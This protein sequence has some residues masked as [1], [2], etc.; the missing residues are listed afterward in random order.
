M[1][2][3]KNER[4]EWELPGG[5]IEE[6]ETPEECLIRE[7]HE[8]LGLKCNVKKIIDS[9]VFEVVEGKFVFIVT[10]LCICNDTA[11][12]L[13]S[14]EH[15]EYRWFQLEEIEDVNMPEGYKQSIRKTNFKSKENNGPFES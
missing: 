8:E 6:N 15:K 11:S 13:I 12:I 3:L 2:L 10:Y 5:R 7:I 14:D 4:N 9:W 1:L